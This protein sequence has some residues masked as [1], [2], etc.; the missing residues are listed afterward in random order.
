MPFV[1]ALKE[2]FATAPIQDREAIVQKLATANTDDANYYQGLVILQKIYDELMKQEEPTKARKP[3]SIESDLSNEMQKLLKNIPA[4]SERYIELNTRFHLLIYP[5]ETLKSVEFIKKGLY[6]DLLTQ[7]QVEKEENH[8]TTTTA[9]TLDNN[10]FSGF[11]ILKNSFDQYQLN[12]DLDVDVLAFP[13]IKTAI[14][15]KNLLSDDEEVALLKKLFLHPTEKLL[16]SNILDRLSR[17]WKLQHNEEHKQ[18][19]SWRLQDLPF[20][21]FTLSQMDQLIENIPNIVLLYENFIRTYLEKLVPAPYYS[22]YSNGDSISFW[23]DD[24]NILNDYLKRLEAFVQKLPPI[25]FLLKS[26]VKFHQLRVDIVRQ[27]FQEINLI[28][29]LE[30]ASDK[31]IAASTHISNVFSFNKQNNTGFDNTNGI[32]AKTCI[33]IPLLGSCEI[34]ETDK[35]QVVQEYLT[36]LISQGKFTTNIESLGAYMDYHDVLKPLYAKIMLTISPEIQQS[37]ATMLGS[38]QYER[39]VAESSVTFTPSTLNASVK[40]KPG[41]SIRLSIRTKNIQRLAIRVFQINTENYCRVH[42]NSDARTIADKNNKIDLDGLCPTWEKDIDFSS[43]PAIRVKTSDFTFGSEGFAPE[44]FEGRGLWV[45]EFVGGQNQ[46]RAI[47]QKGYLRHVIQETIAGHVVRVLDET[48]LSLENAKIW[49][50]NQYYQADE[51]NNI[52][53]PY[54]PFNGD[55]KMNKMLLISKVDDFCEPASFYQLAEEYRLEADFYVNPEMTSFNK[56]S[57]VVVNPR[58]TMNGIS[59][60]LSLIEKMSLLVECMNVDGVTNSTTCQNIG[61]YPS[62]IHFE[63]MV[64]DRLTNL[65]FS[66]QAKIKTLNDTLKTIDV[67][68]SI[69][70]S[71]PVDHTGVPASVHLKKAVDDNYFIYAFGKNGE[72]KKDYEVSLKLKHAYIQYRQVEVILKTNC[73]GIIELGK[74]AGIQWIE[75]SNSSGAYKQWLINHNKQSLLPP[76]ICVSTNTAFKLSCPSP[77]TSESLFSLYKIGVREMLIEN[78]SDRIEKKD[79]YIVISGLPEGEYMLYTASV[80]EGTNQIKCTVIEGQIDSVESQATPGE[81]S[82]KE[83]FWSDW[84][85][86][87][88]SYAKQNGIVLHRPLDISDISVSERNDVTIQLQNW[89]SKSFVVITTSTFVPTSSESLAILMNKRS[90]PRTLA[91]EN[92]VISDSKSLFLDDKR[93]GEEYQYVLNRARAEKWVGSNL[94][95]PTLLMYPKKNASTSSDSRYL[96]NEIAKKRKLMTRYGGGERAFLADAMCYRKMG[97][98]GRLT[99]S[100]LAFLDHYSPILILPVSADGTISVERQSLGLGNLVQVVAISGEQVVYKN[101]VL[102]SSDFSEFKYND[103]RQKS[104]SN[105]ALIRSKVVKNLLPKEKLVI[106]TNEY[107]TI[108][109]FEKLFDTIKTISTVGDSLANEFDYLKTWPGLDAEKKLKLHEEKVCHELN[110]WLKKKDTLFFKQFVEPAI[111]SKVQKTFM[112]LYLVDGDLSEYSSNIYKYAQL[113]TVEKSLLATRSSNEFAKTVLRVFKEAFDDKKIDERSD[114]IF[115][116]ILAGSALALPQNLDSIEAYEN[117]EVAP[118]PAHSYGFGAPSGASLFGY[119]S[120]SA[121][122]PPQL[123]SSAYQQSPGYSA[124]SPAYSAASAFGQSDGL[125]DD[126]DDEE[127][128]EATNELREKAKQRQKKVAYEFAKQTSEWIETGYY[129]SQDTIPVKKFW[130]DYLEYHLE[131]SGDEQQDVFLSENFMYSLSNLT[132]IMYVLS[133]IDLPFETETNW[134][135]EVTETNLEPDNGA[136]QL[137]ICASP[138][139]PLMVFY[140]TLTESTTPFSPQSGNSDNNLMLGQELFLYDKNT[141]ID[142][143]ECIKINPLSSHLDP[144]VEYG[145]HVI[146]SNVSGK[147]LTCQVTVQVPTGS[148]PC[149]D[150]PYCKSRTISIDPYATWHKVVGSFYFPSAGEYTIVPVTV[151]TLSGDKLLGMIE[152]IDVIVVAKSS[153]EGNISSN[154]AESQSLSLASWPTLANSGSAEK[155]ISFLENYKKLD[156]LDF[157]MIGWRM[158]DGSFARQVFNTL[159]LGRCFFSQ[160]LWK[161]G[162]YHQFDDIIRDLLNFDSS[163]ILANTGQVFE[164]P[165]VSKKRADHTQI[166]DYYPLLNARA[167]PLKSTSHEI[168]NAQFYERYDKFLSYLSQQS[169]EPSNTDL[170]ILTLYLILQDRIGDAQTT[171]SRIQLGSSDIDC[172]VQTDYLEAYLKTRIPVVDQME[173]QIQDLE[174]VKEI[175]SKYKDFGI[176]KWRKLFT[177]LYDFG[178]EV[179]QGDST[180]TGDPA[181]RSTRIQSEPILEFEIHQE[182]QELIVQYANLKSVDVKYYEMNIEV[183]FSTN[184]FMNDRATSM[185]SNENFTWVKPNYTSRVDFP[186]TQ[187]TSVTLEPN[188]EEDY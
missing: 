37:W 144:L 48:G 45:I 4:H 92:R 153:S 174:S 39:L 9:S 29:Y 18:S 130:I 95:K 101:T 175:A 170:V 50:D 82:K 66:L 140:R 67:K 22:S 8:G 105:K 11:N 55:A 63:F 65:E 183:M 41:D 72:P 151:S 51:S 77:S 17:L 73:E 161:Y 26:A 96:Q 139:H 79:S 136:I 14:L 162:V 89:S 93:L 47:I 177:E 118:P 186:E 70:Y 143:D 27:D 71:S 115:D 13:E 34:P 113:N 156:R 36:G 102:S 173:Q 21:T 24:E 88:N 168:L 116:S 187:K 135:K 5:I 75:Y 1:S 185:M 42:I 142:S 166:Y 146:I 164:S 12:G 109:S 49:C 169:S 19:N 97:D 108:D 104:S 84:I 74:L 179:E 91:Q 119:G 160:E 56:K 30:G 128:Q 81:T 182:Q 132:E 120:S 35:L 131:K 59:I 85:I 152:A 103:L 6:I 2:S 188:M 172:Q 46:C 133:L 40:R 141:P 110:F 23:D 167:H 137:A 158:K 127:L 57:T 125:V 43:E 126:D 3:T 124:Q 94:T 157:S 145:N 33:D 58:L 117:V 54:L 10:L 16:G 52:L 99:E 25:Y 121:P 69:Q 20:Y 53:I 178:C 86:G 7:K 107:E 28:Q 62:S 15:D 80:S 150:T 87:N 61:K 98:I 112:D 184:P 159:S 68:H 148:V 123:R 78:F 147:T 83:H 100:S 106:N 32:T 180:I 90:L 122:P 44:L 155:V 60:P 31:S 134:T 111:K 181:R 165:L 163:N 176:L 171:F 114:A 129:N 138:T 149:A 154:D 76:A 38:S 64:P